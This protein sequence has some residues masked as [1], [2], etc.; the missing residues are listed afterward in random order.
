MAKEKKKVRFVRIRGRIVPIRVKKGFSD[1]QKAA[2]IGASSGV[3][4]GTST[5]LSAPALNILTKRVGLKFKNKTVKSIIK[6]GKISKLFGVA[7][8]L[9]GTAFTVVK[10]IEAKEGVRVSTFAKLFGSQ[11]VGNLAGQF[12]GAGG[13]GVGISFLERARKRRLAKFT[14]LK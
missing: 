7:I 5:G 11:L 14:L 9:G 12:V 1:V 13:A 10:T 3:L 2:S 4:I 8:G 6:L